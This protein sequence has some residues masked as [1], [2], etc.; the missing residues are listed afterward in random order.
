MKKSNLSVL[1]MLAVVLAFGFMLAGCV[2]R[3]E[4]TG[5][6]QGMGGITT[7]E[8]LIDALGNTPGGASPNNPIKVKILNLTEADW[9]AILEAIAAAGKFVDLDITECQWGSVFDPGIYQTGEKF[10]AGLALPNDATSIKDG[11]Y[12]NDSLIASFRFFT[13]LE[14]L[15]A[16]EVTAIGSNTFQTTYMTRGR[17]LTTVS[18]PKAADIG[19]KAF[20][21]CIK[22]TTVDLPAATK[23]GSQAFLQCNT[24]TTVYLPATPPNIAKGNDYGIFHSTRPNNE[25]SGKITI[26]V[27][28]KD[29]ETAYMETWGVAAETAYNGNKGV[30]GAY[31]DAIT[32]A[33]P[34]GVQYE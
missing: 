19:E 23:I 28:S 11:T 4:G 6:D 13:Y 26:F 29:A 21:Y 14:T 22:L 5:T 17:K 1:G 33:V 31:H 9:K 3:T 27:P 15:R 12:V 25:D 2:M 8:E 32:I 18:L 20:S 24:L 10:I 30:Y 34:E 7:I 16:A